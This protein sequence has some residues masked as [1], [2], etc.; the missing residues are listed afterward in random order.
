MKKE[1]YETWMKQEDWELLGYTQAVEHDPRRHAALHI[2][3]MRRTLQAVEQ[4]A[5]AAKW[6]AVAAI[7]SLIV[8]LIQLV[9]R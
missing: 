6:A 3:E 8:S 2:L 4:S 7:G 9:C 5:R 1:D